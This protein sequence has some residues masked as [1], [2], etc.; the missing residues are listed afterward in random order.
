MSVVRYGPKQSK[1]VTTFKTNKPLEF[2]DEALL[3]AW[4]QGEGRYAKTNYARYGAP[5]I[6]RFRAGYIARYYV[7]IIEN[8]EQTASFDYKVELSSSTKNYF[9]LDD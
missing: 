6:N 5:K 1:S 2:L 4:S 7:F 3:A 8:N 9:I